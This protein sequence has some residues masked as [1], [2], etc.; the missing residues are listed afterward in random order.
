[1]GA[2]V[3]GNSLE[4][5]ARSVDLGAAPLDS[6]RTLM[7]AQGE[8]LAQGLS[9]DPSTGAF[10]THTLQAQGGSFDRIGLRFDAAVEPSVEVASSQDGLN[11]SR[12]LPATINYREGE[13]Y[14]A[15]ADLPADT[16]AVRLSFEGIGEQ[17]LRFLF[18]EGFNLERSEASDLGAALPTSGGSPQAGRLENGLTQA[19]QALAATGVAIT[20]A[21]WGARS[22]SCVATHTPVRMA[23]HHTVTPNN[24]SYSMPQRMR[25]IQAYHID[26][27]LWCDVGYHFLIGQ[28]G[29]VYQGRLENLIGA[30]VLNHNTGSAGISFIGDF[31]TIPPSQAMLDAGARIIHA[32]SSSYG[33]SIDR[34]SVMGHR[35]FAGASTACPGDSFFPILDSYIA[36]VAGSSGGTGGVVNGTLRGAI[37]WGTDFAVDINDPT[38]RLAGATVSLAGGSSTSTDANGWYFFNLPPGSYNLSAWSPGY[39]TEIAQREVVSGTTAWGSIML[40]A[41]TSATGLVKGVVFW[42]NSSADFDVNVS[43]TSKRVVG[44]TVTF[45]PGGQTAATDAA[46]WFQAQ[47]PVGTYSVSAAAPGYQSGQHLGP[48]AV[49]ANTETFASTMLIKD[50]G[51][52]TGDIDPPQITLLSP[53]PGAVLDVP[54]LQVVGSVSD[55]SGVAWLRINGADVN[56]DATSGSFRHSITLLPGSNFVSVSSADL[57]GNLASQ[58]FSVSYTG[59]ERA[60]V[61]GI[62]FD[63][64]IG[65][66]LRIGA[67]TLD[68]TGTSALQLQS[69]GAGSFDGD[70]PAGSYDLRISAEGYEDYTDRVVVVSGARTMIKAAMR[71]NGTLV[72]TALRITYPSDGEILG[73]RRVLVTGVVDDLNIRRVVVSGKDVTLS[74]GQFSVELKLAKG[75]NLIVATGFGQ[76]GAELGRSQ[77]RVVRQAGAFGC[78]SATGSPL[79]SRS[80]LLLFAILLLP[81]YAPLLRRKRRV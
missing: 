72:P 20:R 31:T 27:R 71:P 16:R 61:R 35:E 59:V 26:T 51:G 21:Q 64:T 36:S 50:K 10:L 32:L 80:T 23:I 68:F 75:T 46:G 4:G 78:A 34:S 62:V 7:V 25:Q 39:T 15:Y 17:E 12:F 49:V 1:L 56:V 29:Q 3:A 58:D 19:R 38:K 52:A 74:K 48:I 22:T 60:G 44:A 69:D 13:A 67:A 45:S 81:I 57:V 70:L 24:D 55:A 33:I 11:F 73:E 43:D 30:H 79:S 65:E 53:P 14:N 41:G 18:A 77:I 8:A 76:D 47:I 66:L 40:S 9:R 5:E 28:D 37:F 63:E 42:G 2:A 54:D 6:A